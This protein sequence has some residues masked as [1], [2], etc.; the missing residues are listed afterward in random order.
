MTKVPNGI[1][2]GH[3]SSLSVWESREVLKDH[4]RAVKDVF[5]QVASEHAE[6]VCDV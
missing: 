4:K 1:S 3:I 5:L 6:Q 2:V